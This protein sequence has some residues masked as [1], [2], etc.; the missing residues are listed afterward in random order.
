MCDNEFLDPCRKKLFFS[1]C[2]FYVWANTFPRQCPA[3]SDILNW[4]WAAK[5]LNRKHEKSHELR[6]FISMKDPPPPGHYILVSLSPGGGGG[7]AKS[8]K[9]P[10]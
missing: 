5:A 8:G 6:F 2:P 7:Q 1:T 10:C 9:N 4:T 3:D